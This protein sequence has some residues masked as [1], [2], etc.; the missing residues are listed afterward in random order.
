MIL[1]ILYDVHYD[2]DGDGL[3]R[4]EKGRKNMVTVVFSYPTPLKSTCLH[5]CPA[6]LSLLPPP[7][8]PHPLPHPTPISIC[9]VNGRNLWRVC[10][11]FSIQNNDNGNG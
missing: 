6:L 9:S 5:A 8:A 4:K 10:G 11:N 3:R 2:D 7:A 1:M